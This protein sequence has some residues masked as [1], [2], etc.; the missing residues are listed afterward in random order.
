MAF[1]CAWAATAWTRLRAERRSDCDCGGREGRR[2]AEKACGGEC[3]VV[4]ATKDVYHE[5]EGAPRPAKE[6]PGG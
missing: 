2:K 5:R 1:S 4:R 3:G 6:W